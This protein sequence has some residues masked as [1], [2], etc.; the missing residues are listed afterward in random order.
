[1]CPLNKLDEQYFGTQAFRSL[2]DLPRSARQHGTLTAKSR[3]PPRPLPVAPLK[4]RIP[5]RRR[6]DAVPA[7]S[8]SRRADPDH[9][10]RGVLHPSGLGGRAFGSVR[11]CVCRDGVLGIMSCPTPDREVRQTQGNPTTQASR[12]PRN[13]NARHGLLSRDIARY[14]LPCV[15][16]ARWS[17]FQQRKPESGVRRYNVVTLT[18][19]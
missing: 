12:G 1:M 17:V 6:T 5:R 4:G 19:A 15:V 9:P 11:G 10:A 8:R 7:P 18:P 2:N 3:E 16:I 14:G 13:V